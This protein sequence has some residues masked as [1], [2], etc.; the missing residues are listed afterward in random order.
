MLTVATIST[1]GREQGAVEKIGEPPGLVTCV[2]P[3]WCV[4]ADRPTTFKYAWAGHTKQ[5]TQLEWKLAIGDRVV[6][7]GA[8]RPEIVVDAAQGDRVAITLKMPPVKPGITVAGELS[9]SLLAA[10]AR[11]DS[12]TRPL[13]IFAEDPFVDRR[14]WLEKL[15]I[16]LFDPDGRTATAFESHEIPFTRL[17]SAGAIDATRNGVLI[18]GEGISWSDHS[19]AMK[20]ARRA[21]LR[22]EQVLC[23]APS[24]GDLPLYVEASDAP[25]EVSTLL[26][27]HES[28]IRR[29]DKR[30]ETRAWV[31]GPSAVARLAIV[32]EKDVM[33]A[34]VADV[35]TAWPWLEL[36]FRD[37]TDWHK[38]GRLIV[39]GFGVIK[40]WDEGPV[41]RYLLNAIME[42]S[43]ENHEITRE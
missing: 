9:V 3:V 24:E 15:N 31:G 13:Y 8:I 4:F 43:T 26:V 20:A 37:T 6:S 18:I 2:D 40:Y 38:D 11:A 10:N 23:L 33:L 36:H 41:P 1:F 25:T 27:A 34:R 22:G 35:P 5:V 12:C 19:G 16:G 17:N 39:C 21:A 28:V 29:F 42:S 32:S 14:Q 30:F 7:E